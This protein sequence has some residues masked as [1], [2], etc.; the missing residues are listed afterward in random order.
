MRLKWFIILLVI[1]VILL[2]AFE[3]RAQGITFRGA[4]P[5]NH[6]WDGTSNFVRYLAKNYGDVILVNSWIDVESTLQNHLV[7]DYSCRLMIFISPEKAYSD[8]DINIIARLFLKHGFSIAILDEGPYANR[9]LDSLD[10]PVKINAFNYVKMYKSVYSYAEDI[11]SGY[12]DI[13]YRYDIVFSYVSTISIYNQSLCRPIAYAADSVV[14]ALCDLNVGMVFVL[15]DGSIVTNAAIP[16]INKI[17]V[18]TIVVDS[19]I[20]KLCRG[21]VSRVL[22]LVDSSRY[23]LRPLLPEEMIEYGYSG[24]KTLGMILNPFR[25]IYVYVVN[26]DPT[27]FPLLLIVLSILIAMVILYKHRFLKHK[28]EPIS[29]VPLY[30]SGYD[31]RTLM[32]IVNRCRESQECIRMLPCIVKKKLNRR[33]IK[34]LNMYLSKNRSFRKKIL[35]TILSTSTIKH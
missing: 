18:Y 28:E 22:F 2:I 23:S 17:N 7:Q 24:L 31:R 29:I 14:G 25:Y 16:S 30:R 34:E 26:G 15:G 35:D 11:V 8:N 20:N 9:I 10:V 32:L 33:C 13:D 5:Y 4:S 1:S 12:I 21:N 6:R 19:L 27:L 3:N